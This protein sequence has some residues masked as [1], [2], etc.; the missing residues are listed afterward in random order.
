MN[1]IV[2]IDKGSG[3]CNGVIRAVETAEKN[4][5]GQALHS[6]GAIVHNNAE[7]E[8]LRQKGLTVIDIEEMR[9]MKDTTVLIRAHGEP[10]Q[11]YSIAKENNIRLIDCTCPVVL[12]L[13]ERIRETYRSINETPELKGGRIVIF[14]KE[15]HAEVNGL[16]GQVN[17]DAIITDV[18]HSA[19]GISIKG[20]SQMDFTAP[21]YIFSQTTK[22]PQEYELV[23]NV[24]I[25]KVAQAKGC[26]IEE[27]GGYVKIHNTIC[28]QVAQRHSNLVEFAKSKSVILFVSGKESSNG[29]VLYELCRSANSYSY[30]IQ[31]TDQIKR[32]WF[33]DGDS[34]GI[35]G[36]TSTPKWQLEE[37]AA[38]IKGL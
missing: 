3:F 5:N 17:G 13:Q 4:L 38:F 31:G 25:E 2:E 11:T 36:A 29:K 21:M 18:L 24:I 16:V 14:G 9:S 34:V 12:K 32:E 7:L 35:C 28:R 15:G 6:L 26:S 30:H 19:E 27:A 20:I 33:K 8:R 37:A 10:P 1:L 22:D 23:C